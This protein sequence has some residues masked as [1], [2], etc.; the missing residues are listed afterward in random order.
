MA[1]N[2]TIKVFKAAQG[3]GRI[4]EL[5]DDGEDGSS[6]NELLSEA[7]KAVESGIEAFGN[8]MHSD[9]VMARKVDQLANLSV[10]AGKFVRKLMRSIEKTRVAQR[11]ALIDMHYGLLAVRSEFEKESGTVEKFDDPAKLGAFLRSQIA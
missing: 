4:E 11:T 1:L 8:P 7:I 5:I 10:S 2:F 6:I 3:F 9:P